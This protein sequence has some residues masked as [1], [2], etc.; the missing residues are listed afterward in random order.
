MPWQ[1]TVES[2]MTRDV[3]TTPESEPLVTAMETMAEQHVRHVVATDDDGDTTIIYGEVMVLNIP[4]TI[5]PP[6]L[7]K[8][9]EEIVADEN[10]TWHLNEDEVALLKAVATDSANDAGTV[11]VEWHPS[12]A[13]ENWTISSIG[14]ASSEPV[15]WNTSGMHTVQVRAIDDDGASSELQQATVMIHNV[16]PSVTGLPGNTPVFEDDPLDL[17]V[18]PND[19]PSDID[20]LEVCWDLNANVDGDNDGV[21]DGCDACPNDAAKLLPDA[22]PPHLRDDFTIQQLQRLAEAFAANE[23]AGYQRQ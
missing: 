23:V 4:P 5:T 17:T 9:G 20:T 7:F 8:G 14:V 12:L 19:T 11:I 13:D 15:S 10:G 21:A 2:L 22:A 1:Q 16:A 3:I 6:T 18:V